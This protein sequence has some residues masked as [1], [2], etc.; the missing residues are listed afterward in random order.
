MCIFWGGNLSTSTSGVRAKMS[1]LILI[2]NSASLTFSYLIFNKLTSAI[3]PY[4]ISHLFTN[5][6]RNIV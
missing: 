5:A 6:L 1:H 4:N 3:T 2:K